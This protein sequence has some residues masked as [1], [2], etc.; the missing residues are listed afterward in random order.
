MAVIIKISLVLSG[1]NNVVEYHRV[2]PQSYFNGCRIDLFT[3]EID[4]LRAEA[5]T[6]NPKLKRYK[7][8]IRIAAIDSE[9]GETLS[10]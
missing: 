1:A 7:E 3:K 4:S 6:K 5:K 2:L 8:Y 10:L 9:T